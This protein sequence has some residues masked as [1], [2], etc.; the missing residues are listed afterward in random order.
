MLSQ[1]P[2][3]EGERGVII[4]VAS[5]AA[6]EGQIGQSAYSASKGGQLHHTTPHHTPHFNTT[7][8][9]CRWGG[10][11]DLGDGEGVG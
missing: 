8:A 9:L 3:G 1:K 7:I 2:D 11:D 6:F 10:I 5:I 4:M